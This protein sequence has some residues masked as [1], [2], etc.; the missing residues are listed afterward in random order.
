MDFYLGEL[1]LRMI[2]ITVKND[3]HYQHNLNHHPMIGLSLWNL[4]KGPGK[5]GTTFYFHHEAGD[6][7]PI[8]FYFLENSFFFVLVIG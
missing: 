5:L 8:F 3:W 7:N 6:Q 4:E 2:D 1:L